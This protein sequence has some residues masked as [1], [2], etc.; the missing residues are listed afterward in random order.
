MRK[1]HRIGIL[2]AGAWGAVIGKHLAEQ[3]LAVQ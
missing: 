2:G 1:G 3:L